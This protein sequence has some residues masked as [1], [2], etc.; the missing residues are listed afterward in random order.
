MNFG[1]PNLRFP[2]FEEEWEVTI[3]GK[4][5]YSFEYGMN[6]SAIKFDGENRYIRITDIDESSSKYKP[7]FPVSPNGQLI[8][9][10]LV[11]ENDILFARTGASTG[12]SY[13]YN[14]DDGKLY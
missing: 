1:F 10:Y 2:G 12:K 11:S 7:E 9:K 4:C 5:V 8:D 6:A 13:L 14:K 3:L